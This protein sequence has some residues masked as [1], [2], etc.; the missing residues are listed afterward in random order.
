MKGDLVGDFHQGQAP[1]AVGF[2]DECFRD[3]LVG[4]AD[5]KTDPDGASALGLADES[6]LVGGALEAQ[7]GGED[8][9]SATEE[10]LGVFQF[11]HRN[12]T[13]VLVPRGFGKAGLAEF[14]GGGDSDERSEG[15]CHA[16]KRNPALGKRT[17]RGGPCVCSWLFLGPP[18]WHRL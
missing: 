16:F 3:G 2:R 18:P 13:D 7:A 1:P 15:H 11:R 5:A 10:T 4:E 14:Q 6:S 12:P 9:L 8:Q 17:K